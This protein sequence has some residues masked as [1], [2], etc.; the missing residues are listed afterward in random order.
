MTVHRNKYGERDYHLGPRLT[1]E[2]V[3]TF[4]MLT[5]DELI[6]VGSNETRLFHAVE[7]KLD[8]LGWIEEDDEWFADETIHFVEWWRKEHGFKAG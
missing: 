3:A 5:A 4:L 8:D 1:D 6:K 2:Q 7:A